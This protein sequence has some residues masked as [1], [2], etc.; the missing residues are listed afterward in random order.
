ME[1]FKLYPVLNG[2]TNYENRLNFLKTTHIEFS[3]ENGLPFGWMDILDQDGSFLA[4]FE[5]F[6]IGANIDLKTKYDDDKVS[7]DIKNLEIKDWVILKV[8]TLASG[9]QN[10]KESIIRVYFGHKMFLYRDMTSHCYP[11]QPANELI[12]TILADKRRGC[13]FNLVEDEKPDS[14]P[15]KRYKI[16]ESDWEFLQNKVVNYCDYKLTPLYLY[17]DLN[18]NFYFKSLSTMF[19]SNPKMLLYLHG[20]NGADQKAYEEFA[21]YYKGAQQDEPMSYSFEICTKEALASLKKAFILPDTQRNMSET[22]VKSPIA[23]MDSDES[24]LSGSYPIDIYFAKSSD[25]GNSVITINN[26]N[27]SDSYSLL[28]RSFSAYNKMF[29]LEII[30]RFAAPLMNVGNCIGLF[31]GKGHWVNGKWILRNTH[32]A[33]DE[34]GNAVV[35]LKLMRPSFSGMINETTL[36]NY[37]SF[38]KSPSPREKARSDINK[39]NNS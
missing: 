35:V 37:V 19:S 16:N 23:D 38:D 24:D 34:S 29:Q 20:T 17:S 21:A 27:Y 14:S 36:K 2:V 30:T 4:E 10:I 5:N 12:R 7:E 8:L 13:A 11:A 31:F 22:G 26:H 15:V 9:G 25:D 3:I 18:S 6:Q 28:N 33:L 39:R 32:F 1:K